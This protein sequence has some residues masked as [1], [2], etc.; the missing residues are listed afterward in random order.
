M[1][2]SDPCVASAL[3]IIRWHGWRPAPFD[4][5][6]DE[7]GG[8]IFLVFDREGDLALL[9]TATLTYLC[10]APLGEGDRWQDHGMDPLQVTHSDAVARY[11]VMRA[12]DELIA[13]G[14]QVVGRLQAT[15]QGVDTEDDFWERLD[16]AEE[17]R[18][19]GAEERR[20]GGVG[21]RRVDSLIRRFA[22]AVCHLLFADSRPP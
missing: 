7:Q 12:V 20:S 10:Y 4:R 17:R 13:E 9:S 18:S 5:R 11:A 21:E 1:V 6:S 14:W 3:P 15:F 2:S 22:D 19:G 16:C 8:Q